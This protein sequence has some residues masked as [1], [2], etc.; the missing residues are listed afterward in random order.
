MG[1][2][3]KTMSVNQNRATKKLKAMPIMALPF[4]TIIRCYQIVISPLIGQNCRFYP[5]CSCYAHDA[6]ITHGLAKGALLTVKRI[7]KCHP[8]HPG[9]IDYVPEPKNKN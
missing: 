9:G 5:S 6:L 2:A 3:E 4:I 7:V 1:T 8:L